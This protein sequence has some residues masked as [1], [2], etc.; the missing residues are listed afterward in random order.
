M[1]STGTNRETSEKRGTGVRL[2]HGR[3]TRSGVGS[4]AGAWTGV[5]AVALAF[6][7]ISPT[8]LQAQDPG[9]RPDTLRSCRCIGAD[10]E[11]I[12][13]C[14]CV[15]RGEGWAMAFGEG[16]PDVRVWSHDFGEGFVE[17]LARPARWAWGDRSDRARLGV[18]VSV[19]QEAEYESEGVHLQEVT[20]GSPA[21]EAGLRDGDVVVALDGRSVFDP[22]PD[23]EEEDAI[24]LERSVPVQRFLALADALEPGEE[25]EV[26]Y[27]RDGERRTATV[28]PE[29]MRGIRLF[30]QQGDFGVRLDTLLRN[31]DTPGDF[32]ARREWGDAFEHLGPRGD[33]RI[34]GLGE[35]ELDTLVG[36]LD[37]C[38]GTGDGNV[39]YALGN[40]RCVDGLRLQELNPQ[41]AEY[42]GV[43]EGVLVTEV[44][45]RSSLGVRA[46]DVIRSIG[47]RTIE[48]AS[49][50]R[51]ILRSYETDEPVEMVVVRRG[52]RTE[53]RGTRRAP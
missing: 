14:R 45:E 33:I 11:V 46:G 26:V 1:E 49:D 42:F 19:E 43:E 21:W 2:E 10:G 24:D 50:V 41:L 34:R 31:L 30:G 35:G 7:A 20:E 53:V 3:R 28:V 40:D 51:R 47:G 25:A 27:L 4:A 13:G 44:L 39:F 15:M 22:L 32:E 48:D 9:E 5:A 6:T 36:G 8:A 16:G 23:A 17:A 52:E 29:R 38:F 12:E 18:L 37:P